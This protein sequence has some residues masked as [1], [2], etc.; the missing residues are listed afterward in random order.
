VG[1][2]SWVETWHTFM[3]DGI[4]IGFWG[5]RQIAQEL[6]GLD[7]R[8]SGAV[9]ALLRTMYY[10][11]VLDF[12]WLAQSDRSGDRTIFGSRRDTPLPSGRAINSPRGNASCVVIGGAL[13]ALLEL[14]SPA[15]MEL[16]LQQGTKVHSF[17][18]A[19][20]TLAPEG[21]IDGVL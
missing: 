16:F 6:T 20:R 14:R 3:V 11:A 1:G 10:L 17:I 2:H 21:P 4:G 12:A 9:G 15:A 18:D 19:P 5:P 13:P 7:T 8:R